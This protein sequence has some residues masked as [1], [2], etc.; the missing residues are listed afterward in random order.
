[1]RQTDPRSTTGSA[2]LYIRAVKDRLAWP[3]GMDRYSRRTRAHR[4]EHM[5]L[6][7]DDV[8]LKLLK[9]VVRHRIAASRERRLQSSG[10]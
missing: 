8:E 4:I 1:M 2:Q 7:P 3:A 5:G 9:T 6:T 10:K